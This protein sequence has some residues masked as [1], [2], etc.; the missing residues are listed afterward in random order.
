M[1][2]SLFKSHQNFTQREKDHHEILRNYGIDPLAS[3][4]D[5][6]DDIQLGN[7]QDQSAAISSKSKLSK[8]RCDYCGEDG[9]N[10]R[11]CPYDDATEKRKR[12]KYGQY[13][14]HSENPNQDDVDSDGSNV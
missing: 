3:P 1:D 14:R 5:E 10:A 12:S 13:H 8:I 7:I 11:D 6:Q 4:L 2:S 9:H